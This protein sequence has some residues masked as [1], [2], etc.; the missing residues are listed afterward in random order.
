V[1]VVHVGAS[2]EDDDGYGHQE[3]APRKA[4]EVDELH[5]AQTHSRCVSP[6]LA[7]IAMPLKSLDYLLARCTHWQAGSAR[8]TQATLLMPCHIQTIEGYN[9][10]RSYLYIFIDTTAQLSS[11]CLAGRQGQP[12]NSASCLACSFREWLLVPV[13]LE[14][15]Y[16]LCKQQPSTLSLTCSPLSCIARM[17]NNA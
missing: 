14:L 7:V 13:K 17:R 16:K 3:H 4:Q 11:R 1:L 6:S 9:R 12:S 15:A 5:R 8:Q 2:E 10:Q